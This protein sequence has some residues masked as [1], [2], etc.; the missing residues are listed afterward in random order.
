MLQEI[1]YATE[2]SILFF[3]WAC[4]FPP[5]VESNLVNNFKN[6]KIALL[7]LCW[8]KVETISKL[9]LRLTLDADAVNNFFVDADADAANILGGWR[10]RWRRQ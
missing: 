4:N 1:S 8:S 6:G 3:T 9:T 2:F 5:G 10:W 7:F